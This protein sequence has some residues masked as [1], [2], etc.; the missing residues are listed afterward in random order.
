MDQE[1]QKTKQNPNTFAEVHLT[2]CPYV[3]L[4][5]KDTSESS[6]FII[7]FLPGLQKHAAKAFVQGAEHLCIAAIKIQ[8]FPEQYL[9]SSLPEP[10]QNCTFFLLTDS[11]RKIKTEGLQILLLPLMWTTKYQPQQVQMTVL[12]MSVF[13]V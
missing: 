3:D 4:A 13:T 12:P 5:C 1:A 10:N 7:P 11:H 9:P 8:L 6:F 2:S